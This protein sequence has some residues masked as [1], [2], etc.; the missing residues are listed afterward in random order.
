MKGWHKL[1]L[2]QTYN[3]VSNRGRLVSHQCYK[4]EKESWRTYLKRLKIPLSQSLS[5][6]ID[7]SLED[8]NWDQR[9]EVLH[10]LNK[11]EKQK[12]LKHIFKNR[13]N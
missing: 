6:Q 13:K 10:R 1:Y 4:S 12:Y 3:T 11:I 2:I 8:P 9:M 7:L 5:K